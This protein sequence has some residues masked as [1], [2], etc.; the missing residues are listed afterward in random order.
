[1]NFHATWEEIVNKLTQIN[2][3]MLVDILHVHTNY[4]IT[5]YITKRHVKIFYIHYNKFYA[6]IKCNKNTY[7]I[8]VQ[9]M[10][11]YQ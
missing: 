8:Y 7:N 5:N 6:K 10:P 1:M 11:I 4:L 3:I 2:T 9:D